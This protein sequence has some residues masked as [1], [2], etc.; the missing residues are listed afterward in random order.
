MTLLVRDEE[1]ILRENIDFH[2]SQGVD[3]IIATD[4]NSVDS[5]PDIL[6]EYERKGLLHYILETEDN[7]YQKIWVTK[8]ARMA[9]ETF[10]ADWVINN[11]AD[12]FWYSNNSNLKTDFAKI[13]KEV[14]VVE[15]ERTNFVPVCLNNSLF[16]KNMIYRLKSSTNSLGDPLPPKVAHRGIKDIVLS[17]GNHEVENIQQNLIKVNHIEILHFPI[18]TYSQF[19]NKIIKGGAAYNRNPFLT[20][21]IGSTWRK[22]YEEYK[23][24]NNLNEYFTSQLFDEEKIKIGLKDETLVKDLRLFDYMNSIYEKE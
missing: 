1:D 6:K 18:R 16:Y 9:Y 24:E 5:T 17:Q 10:E 20:K 15:I 8:M 22:L 3:F 7:Y 4:N 2:L 19:T 11:D 12:E 14:N 13:P 23:K 21:D